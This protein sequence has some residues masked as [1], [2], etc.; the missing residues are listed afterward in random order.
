MTPTREVLDFI[1]TDYSLKREKICIQEARK[2]GLDILEGDGHTLL[3]DLDSEESLNVFLQRVHFLESKFAMVHMIVT[4]SKSGN[5]HAVCTLDPLF[6]SVDP[7]IRVAVQACLGSDWKKEM[8]ACLRTLNYNQSDSMLFRP[9]KL[10][11]VYEWTKGDTN[12]GV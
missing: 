7:M 2:S 1:D 11:V 4:H 3:F 8:L 9:K 12:F 10:Q 5:Y 6:P